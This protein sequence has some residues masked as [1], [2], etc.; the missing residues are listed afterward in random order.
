[1]FLSMVSSAAAQTTTPP[2]IVERQIIVQGSIGQPGR[3]LAFLNCYNPDQVQVGISVWFQGSNLTVI[4]QFTMEGARESINL[5]DVPHMP[6]RAYFSVDISVD[7]DDGQDS[8]ATCALTWHRRSD[9]QEVATEN[10]VIR[11]SPKR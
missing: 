4:H 1:M 11:R 8:A 2:A 5:A 7:A 3:E 9:L 10:P 6:T